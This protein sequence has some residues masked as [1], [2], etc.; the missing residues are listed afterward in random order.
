MDLEEARNNVGDTNQACW[1]GDRVRGYKLEAEE[2]KK[3]RISKAEATS[4]HISSR[5]EGAIS[6]Q[7]A[8]A[9][10]MNVQP[11]L[12]FLKNKKVTPLLNHGHASYLTC[13]RVDYLTSKAVIEQTNEQTRTVPMDNVSRSLL[14]RIRQW[15]RNKVVHAFCGEIQ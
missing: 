2:V 4:D 3:R 6:K 13:H 7:T 14:L 5:Q 11:C 15:Q 1:I 12:P 9:G 10:M 8:K